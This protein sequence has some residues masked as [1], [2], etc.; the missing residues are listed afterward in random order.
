MYIYIY[1]T[2]GFLL[3]C[4]RNEVKWWYKWAFLWITII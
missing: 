1:I 4:R 3:N 2:E